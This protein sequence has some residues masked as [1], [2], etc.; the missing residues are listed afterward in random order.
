MNE[1]GKIRKTWDNIREAIEY[2]AELYGHIKYNDLSNSLFVFGELPWEKRETYR[3]WRNSDD[4]N[5]KSYLEKK[6]GFTNSEK[7]M[8]ALLIVGNNH[9]FNPVIDELESIHKEYGACSGSI[10][11][12]LPEYMG[13]EDNDYNYEVMKIYMLGAISR[14]YHP[15]CKFDYSLILY[16]AQGF[17]KSEF[18][19]HLA[20]NSE[21]FND[22]FNTFDGDKAIE[23]LSGMWIIEMAELKALKSSKDAETFKAFLTSR[24]DTYRAPYSRR[25]EQRPRMCVFAGTTNNKNVFVDKTGNRRFLPIETRKGFET[26]DLFGDQEEVMEDFKKAWSEAMTLFV[27]ASKKPSLTLSKD[28][29]LVAEQMQDEFSEEDYRVGVIQNWLDNTQSSKVCVPMLIEY[30]L[31]ADL[32]RTTKS[33]KKEITEIMENEITGWVRAKTNDKGRINF[34]K[35]GKQL[36][37]VR[38]IN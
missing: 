2:D 24:V 5:L 15:G 21:W 25:S 29:Q 38:N 10:R 37:Y 9:R 36:A 13:A 34:T 11:K 27:N 16:G 31:N 26:K 20:L 17:G 35:Y 23:K 7:L 22:N 28:M 6:Y 8:D 3:E 4:A 1:D 30:A 18:L 14:A 32:E 12:L 19:R 33:Q